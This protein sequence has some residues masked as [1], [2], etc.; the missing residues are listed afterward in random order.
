[1]LYTTVSE[2]QYGQQLASGT[3]AQMDAHM[4][5]HSFITF[6]NGVW[7]LIAQANC[8]KKVQTFLH[9]HSDLYYKQSNKRTYAHKQNWET[10]QQ[11]QQE[12]FWWPNAARIRNVSYDLSQL[13][14]AIPVFR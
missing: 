2:R 9:Q 13:P 10:T 7:G 5:S 4:Y 1:M 11:E 3:I 8:T 6:I 12:Q 14:K